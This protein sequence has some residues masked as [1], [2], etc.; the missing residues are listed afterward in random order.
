MECVDFA[1][2]TCER[3]SNIFNHLF[4]IHHKSCLNDV[5]DLKSGSGG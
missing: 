5:I 1:S 2:E 3:I 4:V